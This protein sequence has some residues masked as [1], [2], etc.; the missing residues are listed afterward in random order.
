MRKN[1]KCTLLLFGIIYILAII[2]NL[3]ARSGTTFHIC[4][5]LIL[6]ILIA[7]LYFYWLITGLHNKQWF[8]AFKV[9]VIPLLIM[10]IHYLLNY[11]RIKLDGSKAEWCSF[12]CGENSNYP[13]NYTHK[14][15]R[16]IK[17]GMTQREVVGLVGEPLQ[18]WPYD[19]QNR[20]VSEITGYKYCMD[21]LDT[22]H[23]NRVV[24][25]KSDT[26][27]SITHNFYYD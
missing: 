3:G 23:R 11:N 22:H 26:V 6:I 25:L 1:T 13:S 2:L 15:F 17:I 16:Q 14:N 8:F 27:I 20:K 12:I 5:F 18:I 4:V 9:L 10:A 24:L 21:G 7:L 19:Y